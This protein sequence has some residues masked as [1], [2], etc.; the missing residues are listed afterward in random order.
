MLDIVAV[1]AENVL[2]NLINNLAAT[3]LDP[4]LQ[5]AAQALPTASPAQ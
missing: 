5:R 1:I 4:Q 2:G 3:T